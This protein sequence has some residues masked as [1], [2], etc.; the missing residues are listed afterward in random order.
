MVQLKSFL[1]IKQLLG[2]LAEVMRA[3]SKSFD[4]LSRY[5]T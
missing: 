4:I 5:Y 1:A 3:H 2:L